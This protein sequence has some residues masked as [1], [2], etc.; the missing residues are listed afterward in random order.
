MTV[1]LLILLVVA[2][3]GFIALL[4]WRRGLLACMVVGFIQDP[5]R[6]AL[7]G[8]PLICVI[9][10][11]LALFAVLIISVPRIGFVQFRSIFPDSA[12]LRNTSFAFVVLVFLQAGATL[13]R[14]DAPVLAGLGVLAYL[15]PLP[16]IWLAIHWPR[17]AETA[18]TFWKTYVVG[19][20]FV[21]A[22]VIASYVG[23]ESPLFREVG[24]G[25]RI[26]D[27]YLG[28]DIQSHSGLMR[29]SEVA[30]WHL[31]TGACATIIYFLASRRRPSLRIAFV[32]LTV[33]VL[34]GLLTGRRK[35]LIEVVSFLGIFFIVL[36]YLREPTIRRGLIS[37]AFVVVVIGLGSALLFEPAHRPFFAYVLRGQSVFRDAMERLQ[38]V[39][40]DSLFWGLQRGDYIGLGAGTAAQGSQHFGGQL[41]GWGAEGGLGKI[42]VELGFPGIVLAL[43][44]VL[45]LMQYIL[46]RLRRIYR[47]DPPAARVGAALLALLTANISIFV[48]ATQIFGDPFVLLLLGLTLGSLLAICQGFPA[49]KYDRQKRPTGRLRMNGY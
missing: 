24:E 34:T 15:A 39:G 6:K 33:F 47:I 2:S 13:L 22:T 35:M 40:I 21:A 28:V 37:G 4:D 48:V 26:Y 19:V 12:M 36:T 46:L 8:E 11:M 1:T 30:A 27:R 45:G 16:A 20:L 9:L 14:Y 3:V 31:G 10:V 42:A 32:L 23:F 44:F 5:L 38:A 17:N 18:A 29:T 49:A 7:P 25:I 43:I 41:A